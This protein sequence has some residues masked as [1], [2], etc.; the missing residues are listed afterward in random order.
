MSGT[1]L[2]FRSGF[3]L[4]D[5]TRL[6]HVVV[7][8]L[9]P[10][11]ARGRQG[12][13]VR[14]PRPAVLT[15]RDELGIVKIDESAVASGALVP[16]GAT[17]S[18]AMEMVAAHLGAAWTPVDADPAALV[19][20]GATRVVREDGGERPCVHATRLRVHGPDH[21]DSIHPRP[22]QAVQ[23]VSVTPVAAHVAHSRQLYVP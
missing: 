11:A 5:L 9:G 23:R 16:L 20:E 7:A 15:D 17:R 18:Q 3:A 10:G 21:V 2:P 22:S 13:L 12:L 6:R 4:A 14:H 19:T 8:D 1:R